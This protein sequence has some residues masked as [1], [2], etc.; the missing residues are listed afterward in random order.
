[1]S[2][3]HG[4][5]GSCAA[6]AV[7][8]LAGWRFATL[9]LNVLPAC[10]PAAQ[11]LLSR[12]R[13]PGGTLSSYGVWWRCAAAY[14]Q[15]GRLS[16]TSV[17]CLFG[18]Q[19]TSNLQ[20]TR[21]PSV[22]S[23]AP[24][25]PA[26]LLQPGGPM[27][28][29]H[30]ALLRSTRPQNGEQVAALLLRYRRVIAEAAAGDIGDFLSANHWRH[31]LATS[32]G[33]LVDTALRPAIKQFMQGPEG[34]DVLRWGVSLLAALPLRPLHNLS[35]ADYTYITSLCVATALHLFGCSVD[36]HR[37][38]AGP[39]AAAAVLLAA[40]IMAAAA[41]LM[42]SVVENVEAVAVLESNTPAGTLP[43]AIRITWTA[44]LNSWDLAFVPIGEM[45]TLAAGLLW[46]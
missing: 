11:V 27:D 34:R 40:D 19:R 30:A 3:C 7:V 26:R 16:R 18:K 35:A 14:C 5:G 39:T 1:M 13:R 25:P 28:A 10:L 15:A 20:V 43:G 42:T 32:Y 36:F 23:T 9:L 41:A 33:A 2:G 37:L 8:W 38:P 12:I 4:A 31:I 6:P 22:R 29:V 24:P 45:A 21:S 46:M 17:G 44:A